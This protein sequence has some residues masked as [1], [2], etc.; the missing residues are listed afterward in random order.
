MM[1]CARLGLGYH[2]MIAQTTTQGAE[3]SDETKIAIFTCLPGID[4]GSESFNYIA[5][6]PAMVKIVESILDERFMKR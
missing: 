4:Q 2:A 5:D 1:T 3:F 6:V